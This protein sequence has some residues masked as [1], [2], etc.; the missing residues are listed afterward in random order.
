MA[1]LFMKQSDGF[2]LI[3]LILVIAIIGIIAAIAAPNG[4]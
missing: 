3:E 4:Q 2:S 1:Y